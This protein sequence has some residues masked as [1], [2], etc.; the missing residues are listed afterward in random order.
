MHRARQQLLESLDNSRQKELP[1]ASWER[2]R[3]GLGF[4]SR[5]GP[6]KSG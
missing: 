1:L 4:K 5:V 3:D 2:A 6:G